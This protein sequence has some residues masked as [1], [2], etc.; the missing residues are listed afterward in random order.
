MHGMRRRSKSLDLSPNEG[1]F[2]LSGINVTL[3]NL[4]KI[5]ICYKLKISIISKD[6]IRRYLLKS[7]YLVIIIYGHVF[8]E[9]K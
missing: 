6:E 7:K 3:V 5:Y 9:R 2:D 4:L 1:C 8:S